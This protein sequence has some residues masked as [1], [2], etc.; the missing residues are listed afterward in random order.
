MAQEL[1]WNSDHLEL[2]GWVFRTWCST[3]WRRLLNSSWVSST[4]KFCCQKLSGNLYHVYLAV[5]TTVNLQEHL[6]NTNGVTG[7]QCPVNSEILL[8]L[9]YG[10]NW[11]RKPKR[12]FFREV[13]CS[14]GNGC[15]MLPGAPFTILRSGQNCNNFA[16]NIFYGISLMKIY[17]FRLRFHWNL[18]QRWFR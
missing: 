1:L 14:M 2:T 5:V 18:F 8:T 6:L 15:Q 7:I 17:D 10:R 16:D 4:V 12:R 13:C 11:S 3:L 9:T